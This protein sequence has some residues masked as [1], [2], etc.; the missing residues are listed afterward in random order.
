MPNIGHGYVTQ[1]STTRPR[2]DP[3]HA[4]CVAVHLDLTSVLPSGS[5]YS[6]SNEIYL[7]PI[8]AIVWTPIRNSGTSRMIVIG[9]RKTT[10]RVGPSI[11]LRRCTSVTNMPFVRSWRSGL[12]AL[13]NTEHSHAL[14]GNNYLL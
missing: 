13:R 12:G 2:V 7:P 3:P 6:M 11:I 9:N 4:A 10:A 8:F 1:N 14:A 5:A